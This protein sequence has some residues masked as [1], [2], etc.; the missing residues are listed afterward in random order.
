MRET[1]ESVASTATL[2]CGV[3]CPRSYAPRSSSRQVA[4]LSTSGNVPKTGSSRRNLRSHRTCSHANRSHD[5][6]DN[7]GN[8][9][10]REQ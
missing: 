8:H 7:R 2:F 1:I 4:E 3:P 6:R 10:I 5:K 9:R